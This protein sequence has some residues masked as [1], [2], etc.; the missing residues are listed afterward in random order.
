MTGQI[1]EYPVR[2]QTGPHG[3]KEDKD[4]N[5]WF[6]GNFAS[7]IGKLDPKTG[8]VSE[9]PMPDPAAKDPHSLVFDRDGFLWF[10]GQQGNRVGRLD[11]RSGEV[12]LRT[13]PTAGA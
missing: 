5:I 3:L 1:K 4:G 12:K 9:Y 10:T 11:P 13:P 7:V 6:T 2:A 8:S